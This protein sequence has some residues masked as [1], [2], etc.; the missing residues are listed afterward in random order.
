MLPDSLLTNYFDHPICLLYAAIIPHEK[1]QPP[2]A[3]FDPDG[4]AYAEVFHYEIPPLPTTSM[5][6]S[7]EAYAL[8]RVQ[9]VYWGLWTSILRNVFVRDCGKIQEMQIGQQSTM[10][11]RHLLTTNLLFIHAQ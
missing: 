4:S 9:R 3:G 8:K 10:P 5:V 2:V 11:T 1:L 6:S 7:R